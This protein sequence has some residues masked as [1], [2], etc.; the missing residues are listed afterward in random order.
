MSKPEILWPKAPGGEVRPANQRGTAQAPS[1]PGKI[2]AWHRERLAVVYIRQST[3]QQVLEHRESTALQYGLVDLA[4][5][6]GWPAERVLVIDEDQGRSGQTADGRSGFQHL[7]VEVNL[8]H[9][10]LILGTEMSRLARSNADWHRLLEVCAL[11][12]T[13]LADP[14]GV[15]DPGIPNDRLLLGL[16]GT[17]SEAELHTMRSRLY[18]GRLNKARRGELFFHPPTGYARLPS[19]VVGFD[20]DAQV[21]DVTH[22][23]FDKFD[24]LGTVT[25]LL[26]Y[27]V[28]HDIR[29]G[30]RPLGGPNR[31]QL[32]WHPPYR[33]T[34]LG[35]LHH[36]IY[37]GAYS[38]GRR[39]TDRRRHT[40]G[41]PG[42]GRAVVPPEQWQV[43]L[44]G[45][46]PAYITW[47][48]Y[49]ANQRRL[50]Q[51]RARWESLGAPREGPTL[52]G[53]LLRCGRCGGRLGIRYLGQAGRP[54]YACGGHKLNYDAP[55]C[56]QLAAGP[57]DAFVSRQVL[58]ALEPAAL[59]LSLQ[60]GAD[61]ERE[62]ER[63]ARHW[64]QRRERAAYEVGRAARQYQAVE[65]E[66]RLVARTLEQLW[67]QALLGQ[68]QLEEAYD[69]F[70]REQP[71]ELTA[72]DREAI[73]SLAGDL[74]GLWAAP[75]TT[76]ADR[77]A[78]VRHLL[79]RVVVDVQG[80]SEVVEVTL[81][82][83]GGLLSH[84]H[85]RRPVARYDQLRDYEPLVE[86]VVELRR[87]AFTAAQIA[88]QLNREGFHPPNRRTT[89]TPGMVR[90]LLCRRGLTGSRPR[91]ATPDRVLG[92]D[93]WWVN[94]LAEKLAVA[95]STVNRWLHRG[96]L[97]GRRLPGAGGQWVAWADEAE[98]ERLRRLR[99]YRRGRD[100]RH[101]PTDLTTPKPRSST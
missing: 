76:P 93:E 100:E 36:P 98:V 41:R 7:L 78:V 90:Q 97:H 85:I 56:L 48:R 50:E 92:K 32:E 17:M 1:A 22:L 34:L 77:Q 5:A 96:W 15:Y 16:K 9:V 13:L 69:R 58:R 39:R 2:Q 101:Y 88:A 91:A 63:L 26:R 65:P 49:L 25:G 8:D 20:P 64:Q 68:R 55:P 10:G 53:G 12:R 80:T 51:N 54:G 99:A 3:A 61:L 86:H 23:L 67:E 46:F 33:E 18:Q 14:D 71:R 43:L 31:G 38:Y 59:E 75:T 29:L 57:L 30:V 44:P 52:L 74:P 83:A 4:T 87:A 37:A 79:E 42:T 24:E 84:S 27:L 82:W 28:R 66:N 95:P 40:P 35:V 94:P 45:R 89:F 72:T 21:Q 11:F 73:R 70:Q 60:A 6:W 81:H 62:R 19:G 47:E